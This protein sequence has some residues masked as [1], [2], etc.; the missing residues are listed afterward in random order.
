LGVLAVF[1][2]DTR[3]P[4]GD[5]PAMLDCAC[6]ILALLLEQRLLIEDLRYEAEHDT[7]T[8]ALNSTAFNKVLQRTIAAAGRGGK[9]AALVCVD[10]DRMRAVNDLLGRGVGDVLLRQV[11]ARLI[12][13]LGPGDA[14]AR[15]GANEFVLLLHECHGEEALQTGVHAAERLREPFP[16]RGSEI[17]SHAS[18]GVAQFPDHA[19]DARTLM[20]AVQ[21]TVR[22]IKDSGRNRVELCNPRIDHVDVDRARLERALRQAVEL[23]ELL[24]YYQPKHRLP[25]L[26]LDGAEALMRWRSAE[27]GLIS[28][29][30]FIP[31]AE[32]TGEI[33]ALGKWAL[34]ESCR[35]AML[36][37]GVAGRPQR[38]A[39]NVSPVQLARPELVNELRAA[40]TKTGVNPAKIEIE[41][42]ES[43]FLGDMAAAR[44][45]LFALRDQGVHLALDDFGTGYSALSVLRELPFDTI[46]I[47][48]SFLIGVDSEIEATRSSSRNM[49]ARIIELGHD[50]RKE[51]VVEGVETASQLDLL[52][53]MGCDI[54]QGF[55]LGRPEPAPVWE[56][57]PA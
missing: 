19:E 10:L 53:E 43:S 18:I 57:R 44:R 49:L 2:G 37:D 30:M 14:L 11:A 47:D 39:V 46:K 51:I 3:P 28:P 48:R 17:R 42:T 41:V 55:L 12:E 21:S 4:A 38:I 22:R 36:W 15:T 50:L 45:R 56:T 40:L 5:E 20:Q 7:V 1:R 9:T 35:Q 33:L 52:T 31:L 13:L 32:E 6:R 8:R 34:E 54:I 16:V 24:L 25:A 27:L 29:G 23:G 26:V